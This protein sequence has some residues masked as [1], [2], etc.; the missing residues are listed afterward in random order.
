MRE[1]QESNIVGSSVDFAIY[2]V[3]EALKMACDKVK[4][5]A[6]F[7]CHMS[8]FSYWSGR[9]CC[10]AYICLTRTLTDTIEM[11]VTL[12]GDGKRSTTRQ[13]GNDLDE[14]ADIALK[15]MRAGLSPGASV[16]M[17]TDGSGLRIM[18]SDRGPGRVGING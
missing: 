13:W 11:V 12:T 4:Q 9:E 3:G 10:E 5:D 16:G 14:M 17:V 7:K 15:E 8:L 2:H 6:G 18:G 1:M